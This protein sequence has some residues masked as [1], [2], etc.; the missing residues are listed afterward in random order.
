MKNP[1]R[2]TSVWAKRLLPGVG[3]LFIAGALA[4]MVWTVFLFDGAIREFRGP[5]GHALSDQQW[6]NRFG[7]LGGQLA[8]EILLLL[9]GLR[10]ARPVREKS[11][12]TTPL[13]TSTP[14]AAP[15]PPAGAPESAPTTGSAGPAPEAAAPDE[16]PV[17]IPTLSLPAA[18]ARARRKRWSACNI[19][20]T[21]E[22]AHRL[23]H[24]NARSGGVVLDREHRFTAGQPLPPRFVA[25]S[26]SSL[27]QPR[28][29]IA[30]LPPQHVFLRV[31][32]LP[33]SP[34]EETQAMIELQL[35][36]LSP[37]PVAQTV[38]TFHA[39]PGAS[40]DGSLQSVVVILVERKVVEEFLGKLEGRGYL[41]DRLEAAFLDQLEAQAARPASDAAATWIYAG[42]HGKDTALTAWWS[43][44]AL[45]HLSL[46][47]LPTEG[48]RIKSLR[49]Q[50]AQLCWSGEMEGWLTQPPRWHLVADPVNAADWENWLR[51][52]LNEPV[53]VTA[54]LPPAELAARTAA[55]AAGTAP[56][57]TLLPSEFARRYHQQFVDRLWL[58]GLLTAG[59]VYA[60]G[61][62]IYFGATRV[63]AYQAR[64]VEQQVAQLGPT[65]T[66]VLELKG[67][68][69]VLK[70]R[71]NLKFAAL[72]CWKI[73]AENLPEGLV[74]Q[75]S[76]FADGQRLTLSGVCSPDQIGLISDP[77]KF[78]DSV[79]K[80]K[81][82][83]QELF[84]PEPVEPLIWNQNGNNV[85]WHFTLQLK[86]S[87]STE[88]RR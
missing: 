11:P 17:K 57:A 1:S 10:L 37:L 35:E 45:R 26:W 21:T 72:D 88:A 16:A 6:V 85:A 70:E 81:V 78:Y 34:L 75:R 55:R 66:N 41:A 69:A 63:L 86:H 40:T 87:E 2:F 71:E 31:I 79:R 12:A 19:L 77:G 20:H 50:L 38:W 61:V 44:G 39:L 56:G 42:T 22:E 43:G 76:S 23:W 52:A 58:H 62:A 80:A 48:D 27:W 73:V 74:L 67:R 13:E 33:Q 3:L 59:V 51:A 36:K 82:N 15:T 24:F 65:Y 29:N 7:G 8:G 68:Y 83:G 60:V 46:V 49:D 9:L 84:D 54:P 32:E 28:L 18:P 47:T 14:A 53:T 30:W 25:K 4:A 5:Q 64:T